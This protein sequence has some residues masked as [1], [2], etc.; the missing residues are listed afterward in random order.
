MRTKRIELQRFWIN[1]PSTLQ[2]DHSLHG[3]RVLVAM[4]QKGLDHVVDVYFTEGE[5][6]SCR[7]HKLALSPGWPTNI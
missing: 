5:V 6:I 2:P 1:Q 7:V 3:K 4:G